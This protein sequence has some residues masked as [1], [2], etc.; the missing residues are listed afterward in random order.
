MKRLALLILLLLCAPASAQSKY[1]LVGGCYSVGDSGPLRFHAAALGEYVLYTADEQYLGPDGPAATPGQDSVWKVADDLTV[2]NSVSGESLGKP[3]GAT[4]C[5]DF[6]DVELNAQ[7]TP[8]KGRKAYSQVKGIVDQHAHLMAFDFLGGDFHCGRPWSP[9]GVTVA[10][11]D[12]ESI[13]GPQ[14]SAAPVQNFL[15]Y[16]EPVHPHDTVGW[17]TFVDWPKH[18]TLTYEQTYYRW[19][20]RAW[21]GGLRLIETNMVD[22]EVLCRLL[23][24]K[25]TDCNDMSAARR[26]VAF[27]R[28]LEEYVDAQE[29]G[30]GRGWLR[31]VTDPFQA[32][33]VINQGKLAVVMGIEV[34]RVLGCGISNDEPQC[35]EEDIDAGLDEIH[36]LGIR[37]FFPIHKFDNAFGGTKMDGGPVGVF[38]NAANREQT[39]AFWS[40]KTCEGEA[41][42]HE[43]Q[44]PPPEYAALIAGPLAGLA[45]P[46]AF[47]VYPPPPHCNTRGLTELGKHVLEGMMDRGFLIEIDHM[48]A[49]AA[50]EALAFIARRGYSGV[51]TSHSWADDSQLKTIRGLGGSIAPYGGGSTGF[52]KQWKFDR[53][54]TKSSRY[55]YAIGYGADMNG[56]GAQGPPRPDNAKNPVAYPFEGGDGAVTFSRQVSGEQEYDINADGVAHYGMI[57]DWLE[58]LRIVGGSQLTRDLFNSAEMYV[59]MWERA[60]GIPGPSCPGGSVTTAGFGAIRIGA[61]FKSVLEEAGQP[62]VR[63]GNGFRWCHGDDRRRVGA[64]FRGGRVALA[65]VFGPRV[66]SSMLSGAREITHGLFKKRAGNG[67]VYLMRRYSLAVARAAAVRTK[68]R[69]RRAMRHAGL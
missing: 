6:P 25:H 20:Q 32:R 63:P 39:G 46:G 55:P 2:T 40:V 28:Q 35:S 12:C 16:G 62:W 54:R 61:G 1:D 29:G 15:D 13:Q 31:I 68:V 65:G 67:L 11:P 69:A 34:S 18:H 56:L 36:R 33:K 9:L 48:S 21:M 44:G 10:L 43:Q 53:A 24:M 37:S 26:Q 4:A 45:P 51:M 27:L 41:T 5:A 60:S 22:N 7:G 57:P 8:A 59:S 42:D 23:P 52:V 38:I 58:D 66:P 17:P 50:D 19:L 64:E 3:Q 30:P 47:P 49:R 14:G